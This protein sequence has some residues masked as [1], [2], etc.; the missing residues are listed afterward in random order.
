MPSEPTPG[1][2]IVNL[3]L[4]RG[5]TID[6][7]CMLTGG[8]VGKGTWWRNEKDKSTPHPGTRKAIAEV[9]GVKVSDIWPLPSREPAHVMQMLAGVKGEAEWVE[10]HGTLDERLRAERER[11]GAGQRGV[12]R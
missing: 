4:E 9:L 3:R 2:K 12:R 6:Q 11:G 1:Q 7:C 10:Q 8:E 5:F